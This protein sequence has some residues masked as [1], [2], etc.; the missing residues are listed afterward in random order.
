MDKHNFKVLTTKHRTPT[1][2]KD[3]NT[4]IERSNLN[5][6]EETIEKFRQKNIY[7]QNSTIVND[8]EFQNQ[9]LKQT[10]Q[11]MSI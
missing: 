4:S 5:N 2:M 11:V 7:N 6:T 1:L 8:I 10:Y 3:Q 9:I